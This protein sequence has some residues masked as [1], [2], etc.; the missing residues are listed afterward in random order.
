MFV[1]V[2]VIS[3]YYS[4]GRGMLEELGFWDV[5]LLFVAAS[6]LSIHDARSLR[7]YVWGMMLGSAVVIAY[8]LYAVAVNL[9][10]LA[11]GRAGAYGMYENH[12]DYTFIIIMVLPF[13]YLFVRLARAWLTK[14]LLLALVGACMVGVALSLSRGGILALVLEGRGIGQLGNAGPD[15]QE[16]GPPLSLGEGERRNGVDA[17][18]AAV[19][20]RHPFAR[21]QFDYR[22]VRVGDE[23]ELGGVV[24][25][26]GQRRGEG[27]SAISGE[28][29]LGR[30][31]FRMI[32]CHHKIKLLPRFVRRTGGNPRSPRWHRLR[33]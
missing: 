27:Q 24:D 7:R 25:R 17:G 10:T 31:K 29:R 16:P 26:R 21:A 14:L 3:V 33:T 2:Q 1:L 15:L 8:G 13:A 12:N 18:D 30:E 5:Y 11:D 23:E 28:C 22:G 6:L 32:V 9:P 4:G 19:V 20:H